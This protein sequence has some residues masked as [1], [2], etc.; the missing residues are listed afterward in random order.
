MSTSYSEIQLDALRELANIASGGAATALSQML[1][2]EVD[3]SVPLAAAVPLE[4][5]V[6][7]VGDPSEMVT[8]VVLGVSEGIDGLVVLLLKQ[9]SATKFCG[10][11]GVDPDSEVGRSAVGEIGN[12]VGTSYLSAISSMTAL[13]LSPSTPSVVCDLLGAIVAST[14][15]VTAADDDEVILVDS[16]LTLIGE[17]CEITFLLLPGEGGIS[18]L[19]TPLGLGENDG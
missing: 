8:G 17:R 16:N 13:S 10:L 14:L 12:I 5:A 11:L 9:D 1:G 7:T 3:L 19:L 4:A 15:A 6:E 2:Q 18:S